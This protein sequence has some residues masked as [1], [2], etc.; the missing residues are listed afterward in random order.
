MSASAALIDCI[1]QRAQDE[2]V[3]PLV[4]GEKGSVRHRTDSGFSG[5][6]NYVVVLYAIR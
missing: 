2:C 1:V 5:L 6:T 3:K 4:N